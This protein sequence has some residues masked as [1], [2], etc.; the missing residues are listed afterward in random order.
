MIPLTLNPKDNKILNIRLTEEQHTQIKIKAARK[1]ISIKKYLLSLVEN[2][3]LE[4]ED[5]KEE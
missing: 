3:S 1:G 4:E 2:D 5:N